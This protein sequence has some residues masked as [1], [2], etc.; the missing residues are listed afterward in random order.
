[1]DEARRFLRYV[2]PGLVFL[3]ETL[4][5]LFV[6]EWDI[7]YR[8]VNGFKAESGVGLVI[9]TLFASGGVGFMFS[10]AHHYVHWH[11]P[12]AVVDH[13][14]FIFLL[15][16]RGI[17]RLLDRESGDMLPETKTPDRIQAYTIFAG[18]WHERLAREDSI[19]SAEP[20]ASSLADLYHSV[21]TARVA[22]IAAWTFAL[23]ILLKEC[24][25]STDIV[26]IARF[27]VGNIFAGAFVILFHY[28]YLTI[29]RMA[30]LIGEQ[31]L[32]DALTQEKSKT[33]APIDTYVAL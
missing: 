1:M 16:K 10:V 24:H 11:F 13:R 19:K 26:A 30:Q 25:P 3:T 5:L 2:T 7:V 21:G 23:L 33:Q 20:R 27:V 32:C 8:I 6:I 22:S 31:V 14:Q 29:G 9:A 17:I 4:I 12:H 18:L 28:S 15:R